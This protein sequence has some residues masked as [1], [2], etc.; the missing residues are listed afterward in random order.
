MTTR[1][2]I[3]TALTLA[4]LAT[5]IA[6]TASSAGAATMSASATAPAIDSTDIANY[7]TVTGTDKWW[8]EAKASGRPK[9]QTFTTGGTDVLLNALTYQ[10][11][12]NQKAQ[13]TKTYVI[14]VGTV[15]GS[16]FTEIYR[17]TATQTFTWNSSEY[18][19]WTFD[20][21]LLLSANTTYG[22]DV[23]M[24]SS[25]SGWQTGIPYLNRTA[26]EYTGGTRYM[27]GE[28]GLGIGDD[29]MN[30]ISGDMV[31]HLDLVHPLSPS[32]ENGATVPAGDVELSWTNLTPNVGSNVYVDVWFGTDPVSDFV[33]AVAAGLNTTTVT[34]SAPVA[35]TYYWRI[36]SYLDGSPTGSPIAGTAFAFHV[37]D[38]DGDGMPDTYELAHTNPQSATALNPGDDLENGGAGDGLTNLQEYEI[39][40]NPNDPDTDDDTLQDGDEVIGAGLRPA[41]DPNDSDSDDDGLSDGVETNTGVYLSAAD[42]GTDPTAVD[43]DGDGL[44]D[45][46][47]T[48][49]G[50]YV[51]ESNTGTDPTRADTDGD[52]AEDWYEVAA[53]F[54]D[55]TNPGDNPIIPYPLPDPDSTPPDTTKPVKVYI[56]SGQSNMVGMG[57]ISGTNPGTLETVTKR[58][59]K[60]P[61]LVDDAGAWTVRNDVWYKGV[62]TAVGQGPLTPGLQGGTI[63]P[64]MGFGH[65]MGYY[66]DE[67]VIVLKTSQGN[68]SIGWDFLP[69]GSERYIYGDYTHAGYGDSPNRWLTGT[70]PEPIEWYAGKQYDDCVNA[71]HDVLDNF[72]TNFPQWADQGYEIAGFG[73]WQGHKD[74]YDASHA[75]RYELNLANLIDAL[76]AEFDAPDA[77]FVVATIGFNGGPYDPD[78]AYGKIHAAQMAISDPAKHPE[79]AGNVASADTLAYWR[80]V[81]ESPVSQGYHYN[82]NAETFMLVGDAMGRAML[83]LDAPFSVDAGAD[84]VTWSGEPVRLDAAVQDGVAVSSYAWAAEPSDGVVLNSDSVEDPTVTITKPA[85]VL[86]EVAITNSGFESPMLADGG[87]TDTPAAWTNGYYDM[88]A[89]GEWVVGDSGAGVYN[90]TVAH[91]YGGVASE[92]DNAGF[93]TSGSG[94]DR[95]M[96]QVLSVR[97]AANTQ[98]DLSVLVGNPFVF[99]GNSAT[100]DYRIELLAGGVVL[101]SD[102][103]PSPADDTAWTTAGLTYNSGANP[104]Q[105][106]HPLEIRL[107]AADF[108]GDKGVDFDDVKLTAEGPAP[109]PYT[110]SL[111]LAVTAVDEPTPV[112]DAMVVKVYKDACAAARLGMSLGV[113]NPADINRDCK[114][115]LEDLAEIAAKWLNDTGLAEPQPKQD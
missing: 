61:N 79:Y 63:G 62:V 4:A 99:N 9:G 48:N 11:S 32:P 42:T 105:S 82:R 12:S 55:P 65:V 109:D 70:T 18:M 25:T 24:T 107:L 112:R 69:P 28:A 94:F 72:A 81:E 23:G 38:T 49:T 21:P 56:L 33:K 47:E 10:V 51:S 36:D 95:G 46:V 2:R 80:T 92:G 100:A 43:S 86:T 111:R 29:T 37:D 76:R 20:S 50:T 96:S 90:P 57:N 103:G 83:E 3:N 6:L 67:P 52:D 114:T 104:S 75:D 1:N 108:A 41:T 66:H 87:Y 78:S 93:T 35:G 30:N 16:T 15:S 58:E 14:R 31:F 5:A 91:G 17:E 97:L 34:V 7:G 40:T 13:P 88:T 106:G 101:A 22:I 26:D 110:V 60:F 102:S 68:R 45:G 74:Q 115:D 8:N 113:N 44:K 89:P 98:Y 64:E 39:G 19:T 71:A 84:M 27:S 54:T 85:L 73:W 59:N 53:A 77:P